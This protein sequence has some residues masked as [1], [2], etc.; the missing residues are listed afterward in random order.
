MSKT[1]LARFRYEKRI[2][3]DERRKTA[4]EIFRKLDGVLVTKDDGLEYPQKEYAF[5]LHKNDLKKLKEYLSENKGDDG[6]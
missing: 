1:G 4:E 6:K 2:R 5:L 3:A